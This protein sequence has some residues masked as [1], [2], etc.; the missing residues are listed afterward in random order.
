MVTCMSI[1]AAVIAVEMKCA[2]IGTMPSL[3]LI[4]NNFSKVTT[5]RQSQM[6]VWNSKRCSVVGLNLINS[7]K[8]DC[9]LCVI[10]AVSHVRCIEYFVEVQHDVC[11]VRVFWSKSEV[12]DMSLTLEFFRG[13]EC[14]LQS[15]G[16]CVGISRGSSLGSR[17]ALYSSEVL[18]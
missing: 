17:S 8:W 5:C 3:H 10:K 11:T 16:L 4:R 18:C 1:L 7:H 12:A 6:Q 14:L 2:G 15:R 9:L 13:L